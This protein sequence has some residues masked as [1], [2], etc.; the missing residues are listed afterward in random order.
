MCVCVCVC[1]CVC[2]C[3]C[4]CVCVLQFDGF[5]HSGA[6]QCSFMFGTNRILKSR[7]Q[8]LMG[9]FHHEDCDDDTTV[10]N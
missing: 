4:A 5:E 7:Y 8:L 9:C 3:V 10:I 2:V 6:I 1:A